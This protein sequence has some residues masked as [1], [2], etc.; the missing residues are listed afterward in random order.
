MMGKVFWITIWGMFAISV[1]GQ[2]MPVLYDFTEIPQ[3]LLMNPAAEVNNRWY[4]GVPLLSGIRA[5]FGSNGFSAYDLFADNDVSFNDKVSDLVFRLSS[6]DAVMVNQQLEIFNVGF[7]NNWRGKYYFSFGMY[8]ETDVFTYWPE[9]LA[10]LAYEGNR[11]YI[12]RKFDFSHLNASAE[13]LTV[14]HFGVR[15]KVNERLYVGA[16]AKLYSG[17]INFNTTK[18]SGYFVTETGEE[19]FYNH[20]VVS[21]AVLHTSGYA[22]L[23][24]IEADGNEVREGW[25]ELRSRAL[26]SGNMG[27]GLDIGFTYHPDKHWTVTGS[28]RDIGFIRYT[29]DVES[30]RLKGSYELEGIDLIF[31]SIIDNSGEVRDYWQNLRD[32]IEE[33]LPYD[34][35]HNKY[36]TWRPLKINASVSYDFGIKRNR[37]RYYLTDY[38]TL[39]NTVGAQ[40][41]IVNRPGGPL[42]S[43]TGFYERKFTDFLDARVTYTVDKF[44]W[45]NI[46]VGLSSR[47]GNVNFYVLANNVPAFADLAKAHY[48]SVQ[49]GF[50]YIFPHSGAPY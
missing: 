36:T 10:I 4:A 45:S 14:L 42:P 48:A 3:S 6:T 12:G 2:N 34:T 33:Q 50:N 38:E 31:P 35:L 29:E 15:K 20:R 27:L 37:K 28:V 46:G 19:N 22:S 40:L 30:Y 5:D 23:R 18:N 39:V 17:M 32:E 44:S 11:D 7:K 21:D 8:Q 13:M 24:E 47:V 25:K 9:D 16:R 1:S 43:L 49:F 26:F 41:F